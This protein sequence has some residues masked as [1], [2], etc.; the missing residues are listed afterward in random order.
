MSLRETFK[1]L[2]DADFEELV[3]AMSGTTH[4]FFELARAWGFLNEDGS[5][6]E[7]QTTAA[8]SL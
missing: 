7:R 5:V 4:D 8:R 3:R 6:N 1:H 2:S